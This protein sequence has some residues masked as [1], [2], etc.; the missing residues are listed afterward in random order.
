MPLSTKEISVT[1]L[2]QLLDNK[3]KLFF[4]DV[5]NREDFKN[6]RIEGRG[7]IPAINVP[8]FE[9][10][11]DADEEDLAEGVAAYAEKHWSDRLPKDR[12]IVAVCAKGGASAIVAEGLRRLGYNAVNLRGGMDAWGNYYEFR[13]V[14]EEDELT[15][16]QVIRPAR[17]CLSYVIA[18]RGEAVIVDPLR[19][20]DEYL[21]WIK[22]KGLKVVTVLDTHV[23]ADHISGGA[24]LAERLGVPYHFH[25]YDG[26]HPIDVLPPQI[27]YEMVK[28]D[29]EFIVGSA[30]VK[31]LHIP[32]H[33]LGNI[34]YLVNERY[35]LTGDSIF[36]ES[37]ARPDLGGKGETWA[38]I[39]YE[40][41]KR[42]LKLPDETVILPG[43][44]SSPK[45]ANEKGLYTATLGDLKKS[46]EGLQKVMEGKEVFVDYILSSLPHFPPQYVD[47]K[48]VNIGLLKP[49][50]S[51]ASELELGRN[52]CALAQA[53][54]NRA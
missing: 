36:V 13:P 45:E 49:D 25:P 3:E 46:N 34:A 47:I 31:A 27:S 24:A 37:I 41:L 5:R 9:L 4:V 51:K 17:G 23:H 19:H 32:G 21:R 28:P 11:E 42:L 14:V 54:Q 26:I 20:I 40:S 8:Y 1:E 7:E 43:H 10:L 53:Y 15:I 22:D 38:P 48:R 18:S 33:T 35:L 52:I 44:F 30:R 12:T 39:H 6:W 29:Q 16:Q 50:E 2:K